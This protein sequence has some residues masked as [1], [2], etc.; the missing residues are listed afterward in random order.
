MRE[1]ERYERNCYWNNFTA[2]KSGKM[3]MSSSF[4]VKIVVLSHFPASNCDEMKNIS[5]H[6]VVEWMHT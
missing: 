6:I 3:Q 4:K 1:K 5:K 2:N